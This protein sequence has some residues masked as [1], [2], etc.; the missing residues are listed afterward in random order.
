MKKIIR[1]HPKLEIKPSVEPSKEEKEFADQAT[2]LLI[3]SDGSGKP[4]KKHRIACPFGFDKYF[5]TDMEERIK[6]YNE[7]NICKCGHKESQHN[8]GGKYACLIN[9]NSDDCLE[10][11]A[12]QAD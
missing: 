3:C 9:N 8:M 7:E 10:F 1:N 12:K 4:T 6:K 11:E 5:P 2:C